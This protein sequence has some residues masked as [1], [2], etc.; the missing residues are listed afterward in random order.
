L[1]D[2]IRSSVVFI[3]NELKMNNF[4][5]A[6]ANPILPNLQKR[7][8]KIM[9][10]KTVTELFHRIYKGYVLEDGAVVFV[11]CAISQVHG[12]K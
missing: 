1:L 11:L 8:E 3:F 7:E 10:F 5:I 6:E 2:L 12:R 4:K 9:Y